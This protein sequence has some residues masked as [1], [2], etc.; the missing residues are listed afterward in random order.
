MINCAFI[1]FGKSA[2]RY[3]LPYVLIREKYKVKTIYDITPKPDI[4]ALP[5]YKEIHFTRDV[6]DILN[7]K[8][9]QLVV[10][11]T[12]PDTHYAYA[13]MCIEHGKHV[14]VEK[15]FTTTLNEAEELLALAKKHNVTVTPF[16]NRRFDSCFLTT[17]E[18]INSSLIGDVVEIES[19][20]DYF[21]PETQAQENHPFFGAFYGL[22]IHT[23]DQ[24][25][26]LFGRPQHVAYD[27]RSLR[28]P[29]NPDDTF[30]VQLYYG[31]MKAIIKTSHLVMTPYPKFI[32]HGTRGSFTRHHI[33]QQ[34]TCLK[35]N[36]MPDSPLFCADNEA[37]FVEYL[38][39]N[40]EKV[41][42]EIPAVRGDYGRV[43]DALYE[44]IVN[45]APNYVSE[46]EILTNLEILER[47]FQQP[48]PSIIK[49][50]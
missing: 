12:H 38:D 49:L 47:G 34:E 6:N 3:H 5:Q 31:E 21:R 1:G 4:E 28:L 26:S 16:Q 18:V 7:D 30:E 8:S 40:N 2:T 42:K 27:I 29:E 19:H 23:L 36:I 50:D 9:V 41:T 17:R 46:A 35:E 43:Y 15:P 33:D 44:T 14:M 20:F 25:L 37:G 13:R 48:S 10:V 39:E 45:G 22:G 32:V 24:M 11:C